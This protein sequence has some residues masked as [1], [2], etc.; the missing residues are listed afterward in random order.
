MNKL[1]PLKFTPILK[2]KVWGGTKLNQLLNKDPLSNLQ[3]ESWE[4][5]GVKGDVSQVAE[6]PLTGKTLNELL[7]EYREELM[8]EGVYNTFGDTFPLLFKYIDAKLDLSV[9]LHPDDTLAKQRH[10]S[11]GKTEMWYVIQA[12]KDAELIVGFNK[13]LNKADYQKHLEENSLTEVLNFEK[14]KPG[15]AYFISPGRIHA[16]GE[17]VLLAEIQQTSD[18][19]Y[20]VYDWDRPD[21]N[22]NLRDLHN[23]LALDAI[24]FS[25]DKNYKLS[26][27]ETLNQT[28]LLKESPYFSTSVLPVSGKLIRD[29]KLR[30]SF[31]V[32][33]C[34]EGQAQLLSDEG[35]QAISLG[36][37]I[38]I[39]ACISNITLEAQRAKFLEV[40]V[41]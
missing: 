6:G 18:I 13:A 14:V 35:N 1:Y 36:E 8:G 15:D 24:D 12:D 10:K 28:S 7:I 5:S 17:G 16:I 19:T 22:G 20:R 31:T 25:D 33:M 40:Y 2:E 34:I 27:K 30:D 4:I 39:P 32:L 37:T 11:F 9:Q 29:Y 3:G 38:L 26:Y 21:Q 23:D 41:P